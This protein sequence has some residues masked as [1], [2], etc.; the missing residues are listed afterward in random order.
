VY[1]SRTNITVYEYNGEETRAID[2][3]VDCE[4][5][6]VWNRDRLVRISIKAADGTNVSVVVAADALEKA[7]RNSTGA[8]R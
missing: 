8:P 6:N 3:I 4:L 5:S 1:K 7:I 2:P